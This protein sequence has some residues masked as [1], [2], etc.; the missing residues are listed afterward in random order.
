MVAALAL[1]LVP[2]EQSQAQ[3]ILTINPLQ[4]D[5][6]TTVWTFSGSSTASRSGAITTTQ[7]SANFET[8]GSIIPYTSGGTRLFA[9]NRSAA[10]YSLTANSASR[11]QITTPSGTRT[12]SHIHLEKD[13]SVDLVGIRAAASSLSYSTNDVVSWRGQGTL[14]QSITNFAVNTAGEYY[15]NYIFGP[16]FAAAGTLG[17]PSSSGFRIMVS[18]TPTALVPEPEEYAFVFGLSALGFVLFRRHFQKKQQT[19]AATS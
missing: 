10:D 17:T 15:Y 5:T 3:L 1:F 13:D 7:A 16:Y 9:G 14:S 2:L 18:S 4:N 11:P 12:I 6:N 8:I 19:Q